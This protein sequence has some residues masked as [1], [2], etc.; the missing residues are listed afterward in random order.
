VGAKGKRA[1][2]HR[3]AYCICGTAYG[4]AWKLYVAHRN[5]LT[6]PPS[7]KMGA[8]NSAWAKPALHIMRPSGFALHQGILPKGW[9]SGSSCDTRRARYVAHRLDSLPRSLTTLSLRSPG[10]RLYASAARAK[11]GP[12]VARI[13][14]RV[15]ISKDRPR[16]ERA[17]RVGIPTP[18]P[19]PHGEDSLRISIACACCFLEQRRGKYRSRTGA[20]PALYI[21]GILWYI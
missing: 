9:L 3:T 14:S 2:R 12:G 4:T 1:P 5:C 8:V 17:E 13:N 7:A 21:R 16:S 10:G 6:A 18:S 11:T 20:R 15:L 19:L